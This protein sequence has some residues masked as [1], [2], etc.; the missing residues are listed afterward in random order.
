MLV[1]NFLFGI[2]V[3]GFCL[4]GMLATA[5]LFGITKDSPYWEIATVVVFWGI[6]FCIYD[7]IKKRQ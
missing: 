4:L 3:L 7:R 6:P 1:I 5:I 2:L